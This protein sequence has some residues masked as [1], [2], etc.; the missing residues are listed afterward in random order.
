MR[1]E[2]EKAREMQI[3]RYSKESISYNSQLTPSLIKKYCA[4]DKSCKELLETAFET[5]GFTARSSHKIIKMARTIADIDGSESITVEHLAEAIGYNRS[6]V[7][8]NKG[9]GYGSYI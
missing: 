7:T 3:S 4:L 1:K 8:V 5:Y 2:V 6:F 9:K